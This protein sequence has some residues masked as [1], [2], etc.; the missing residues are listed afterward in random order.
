MRRVDAHSLASRIS[1]FLAGSMPDELL[2]DIAEAGKLH[3]PEVIRALIPRMLRSDR[4]L[5]VSQRFVDQ[6]LR[7]RELD[8]DKAPD[9]KLFPAWATNE[10]LRSDIRLQPALFFHE[11]LKRDLPVLSLIDS[12]HTVLTGLLTR[13][14]GERINFQNSM[15]PQWIELPEY[16]NRGG[17]LGMPAVLAVSSYPYRTSP[18]LRGAWVLDSMLGTP[19][20]P[21]PADVPALEKSAGETPKSVRELLTVHRANAVCASCHSRIDPLGFALENFDAVGRWRVEDNGKPVDNTGQ[22]PDG[23]NVQG[24]YGLKLALLQRKELFVRNLTTK[25]LGF[26]LGRGLT[27]RDSCTVDRIVAELKERD[28]RVQAL[29][30]LIVLSVPF[31]YQAP[32]GAPGRKEQP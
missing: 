22:L 14:M 15:Q 11:M 2:M 12:T 9:A 18:V 21:P 24:P 16:S 5:V 3:Q 25:M 1:Y 7:T 28:Y 10:E 23:A 17:L 32:A 4:A 19:P 20:P 26:A 8:A 30:E 6:W 31:Q 13:H 29:M 27:L